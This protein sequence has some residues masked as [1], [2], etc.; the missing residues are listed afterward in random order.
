MP[1]SNEL[2]YDSQ[3]DAHMVRMW[4]GHVEQKAIDAGSLAIASPET[5]P[6]VNLRNFR[7]GFVFW[8]RTR[9]DGRDRFEGILLGSPY[10]H[11]GS[12]TTYYCKVLLP[13]KVI[14]ERL[15]RLLYLQSPS[16]S[17][18]N[19]LKKGLSSL[20]VEDQELITPQVEALLK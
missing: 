17:L 12:H 18:K 13:G 10:K 11:A 3:G 19:Q 9:R 8:E 6:R 15:M 14:E 2:I 1:V 16:Q 7:V 20:E 5:N 4:R